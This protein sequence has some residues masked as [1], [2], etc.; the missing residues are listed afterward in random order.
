[1]EIYKAEELRLQNAQSQTS[2]DRKI[3]S[4]DSLTSHSVSSES[5]FPAH[6]QD[7]NNVGI[8]KYN[9]SD[10]ANKDLVSK[11]SHYKPVE[12]I[13]TE[14][15]RNINDDNPVEPVGIEHHG[16]FNNANSIS[17]ND[18]VPEQFQDPVQPT[19]I[20]FPQSNTGNGEITQ[21]S[22]SSNASLLSPISRHQWLNEHKERKYGHEEQTE[23]INEQMEDREGISKHA[24]GIKV[25]TQHINEHKTGILAHNEHSDDN[26]NKHN[27]LS[28]HMN[29]NNEEKNK[30]MEGIKVHNEHIA[31]DTKHINED[32]KQ[33][34]EGT[35]HM[36]AH[37]G[38][39][40]DT[41]MHT[42][43]HIQKH[44]EDMKAHDQGIYTKP[45]DEHK[46]SMKVKR[47]G[48]TLN[49]QTS[50]KGYLNARIPISI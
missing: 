48:V 35:K 28:M 26:N 20:S 4:K 39:N 25:Q 1:M 45:A 47:I 33:I 49:E 21:G 30:Y 42:H 11:L 31:D 8:T 3:P 29:E 22:W 5:V 9:M 46:M 12:S 44:N 2:S 40:E 6:H 38:I 7:L 23:R 43:G 27:K 36:D 18:I 10:T 14:Q 15:H 50:E 19:L 16:N 17:N 34:N 32:M 37:N 41:Q 13:G 24:E